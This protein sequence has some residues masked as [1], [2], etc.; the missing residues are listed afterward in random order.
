MPTA[1]SFK[2][3]NR[4]RVELA[5]GDSQFT[6]FVFYHDYAPSKVGRDTIYH[7]A[8]RPSQVI[9]PVLPKRAVGSR[10]RSNACANAQ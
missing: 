9:L 10:V 5:N 1:Y 8:D 3:G 7:D 2:R 4:V 6:E